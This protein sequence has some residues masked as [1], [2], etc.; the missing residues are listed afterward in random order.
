MDKDKLF[1]FYERIYFK[2]MDEMN[3]ILSRFPVLIAGI[4]LTLSAYIFVF[5][6]ES[7]KDLSAFIKIPVCL[8]VIFVCVRLLYCMY[9]TL[10][11]QKY[12]VVAPLDELDEYK[13]LSMKHEKD[14]IKYNDEYPENYQKIPKWEDVIQEYLEKS[15]IECTT[16]NTKRN[17]DRRYWFHKSMTWIWI[18]LALCI[19]IPALSIV[20]SWV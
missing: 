12:M 19:T 10:K 14:I 16:A 3:S 5:S 20:I 9:K 8:I 11:V 4:A 18:N 1:D 13:E 15:F 6:F 17:D 2:E 7:F